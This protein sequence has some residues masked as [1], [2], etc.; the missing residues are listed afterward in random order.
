M[1]SSD[2]NSGNTS[3][4]PATTS[5]SFLP[6]FLA[7]AASAANLGNVLEKPLPPCFKS[8]ILT[9]LSISTLLFLHNYRLAYRHSRPLMHAVDV[10][11]LG[12]VGTSGLSWWWCVKEKKQKEEEVKKAMEK[13]GIKRN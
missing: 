6:P 12:F 9:G 8:P 11:I 4:P 1:S 13:A 7:N 10:S 5:S 3:T 2:E